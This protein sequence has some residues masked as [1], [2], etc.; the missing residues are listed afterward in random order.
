MNSMIE[1]TVSITNKDGLHARPASRFVQEAKRF[2][3]EITVCMS[4]QTANAKS[5]ISVLGL[6]VDCGA[7]LLIRASGIDEAKAMSELVSLL[8]NLSKDVH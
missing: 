2:E 3:S 4:G 5:M 8:E 1:T 6:G 7:K